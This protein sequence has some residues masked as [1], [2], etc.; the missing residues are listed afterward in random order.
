MAGAAYVDWLDRN[1]PTLPVREQ[2]SHC[3]DAVLGH[4]VGCGLAEIAP[5]VRSLRAVFS[6]QVI[7][8]VDRKPTLLAWLSTHGVE[9]VI[10]A[11]RLLH[12]K[13]H[14][15]VT[16]FAVHAQVL[17]ERSEIHN[18]LIADVRDMVF[19]GD[20]L[21][22]APDHC[23]F[24]READDGA[25]PSVRLAPLRAI[26]AEPLAQ[27]LSE[28]PR[29]TTGVIA[30][31]RAAALRFCR[32]MLLLSAGARPGE[33]LDQAAC[34]VI[35]HLGLVGGEIRPNFDR[36][37]MAS[38]SGAVGPRLEAGRAVNPDGGV[39]PILHRYSRIPGLADH[40]CATWGIPTARRR[41]ETALRRRMQSF[42]AA[43]LRGL[44]ELR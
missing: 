22:D 40:A 38:P 1:L 18:V 41:P 8:I 7:L 15:A 24:F 21:A 16:R 31:P 28:R 23:Q 11:D 5:F 36:V 37:A 32:T 9:T 33:S 34:N 30:G 42:G 17:Q 26:V 6:G 25:H 3:E 14:P 20:P 39:S 2:G 27:D 4:A 13:P 35:A 43:V 10:A 29:V 44:P 19:Q 12:W